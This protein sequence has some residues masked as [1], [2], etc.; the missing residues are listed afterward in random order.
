[1]KRFRL[2]NPNDGYYEGSFSKQSIAWNVLCSRFFFS[3]ELSINKKVNFMVYDTNKFKE[4]QWLIINR[5]QSPHPLNLRTRKHAMYKTKL[6][7]NGIIGNQ[8]NC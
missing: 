6:V 8:K 7:Q 2:G 5:N 1:M 4:K 3:V